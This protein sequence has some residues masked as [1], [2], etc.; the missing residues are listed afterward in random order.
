MLSNDKKIYVIALSLSILG[1]TA[2]VLT[3]PVDLPHTFSN[4]TVADADE[5]NANFDAIVVRL[6]DLDSLYFFNSNLGIGVTAPGAPLHIDGGADA[7]MGGLG[8]DLNGSLMVGNQVG[9]NLA[10]DGNEIVARQSEV[11]GVQTPS[12]LYLNEDSGNVIMP[13]LEITGDAVTATPQVPLHISGGSTFSPNTPGS[14][15]VIIGDASDRHIV[16]DDNE[17]VAREEF[18]G[19]FINRDLFL[20]RAADD[21]EF[22]VVPRLKIQGAGGSQANATI[23]IDDSDDLVI[24]PGGEF[25]VV[26]D[27]PHLSGPV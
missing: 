26:P 6:D 24:N 5:V 20:N 21:E 12:T 4:G 19:A 17:I 10:I 25:V 8:N 1:F 3:A 7:G 16:F 23:D 22:V 18:D 15:Y 11:G 2:K 9:L 13:G 27:Q 14:G